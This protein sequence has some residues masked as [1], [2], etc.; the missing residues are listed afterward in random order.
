M[1]AVTLRKSQ[2]WVLIFWKRMS[3]CSLIFTMVTEVL[4]RG[5]DLEDSLSS[6]C[7]ASIRSDNG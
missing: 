4:Q 6:K 2:E 5:C 3:I 1:Q 7:A